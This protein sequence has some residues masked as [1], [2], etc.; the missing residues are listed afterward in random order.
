MNE[1]D[2][3]KAIYRLFPAALRNSPIKE[4]HEYNLDKRYLRISEQFKDYDEH[5]SFGLEE[6][7]M[8]N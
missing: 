5:T 7:N 8:M 3:E 6:L 2:K 1:I 4:A